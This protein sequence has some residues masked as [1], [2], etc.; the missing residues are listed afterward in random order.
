M[1]D[2]PQMPTKKLAFI[3]DDHISH[4]IFRALIR[5]IRPDIQIETFASAIEA[6]KT[7]SDKSLGASAIILDIN[8]PSL[9]G[10]DFLAELKKNGI[11]TPVY[12]LTSSD[13]RRD[14]VRVSEFSNIQAYFLKPL[15]PDQLQL[16]IE[17][18]FT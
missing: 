8:M 10:W 7:I 6:I 3:D 5:R 4:L 14:R 11:E 9:T 12:M 16:V 13:D 15:R 17:N 1:F 18:H 2:D